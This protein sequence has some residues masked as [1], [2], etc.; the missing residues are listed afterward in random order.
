MKRF[1][2][3]VVLVLSLGLTAALAQDAQ[4]IIT[5]EVTAALELAA[6][7]GSWGFFAPGES[8]II[9]ASTF[10]E[11]AG[12]GEAVGDPVEPVQFD[13]TGDPGTNVELSFV[14]PAAFTGETYFM[15]LPISDWTY[16]YN[17][18]ADPA[19]QFTEAG[20]LV[21]S[22]IALNLGTGTP[23]VFLGA[24]VTVPQT[25]LADAYSAQVIAS[26]AVTGN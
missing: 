20:P 23:S 13:I 11:P 26:V 19:A 25:A 2:F 8:Y 14:L 15:S 4:A 1:M 7:G 18:D 22:A 12:P 10:K 17:Y 24:T 9:T 16:G 21:G 5:A 3:V 6:T